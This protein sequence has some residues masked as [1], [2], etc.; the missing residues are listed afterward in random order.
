LRSN[1]FSPTAPHDTG[2]GATVTGTRAGPLEPSSIGARC[3]D[4]VLID[5]LE[6]LV[7]IGLG[8]FA[9]IAVLLVIAFV[10]VKKGDREYEQGE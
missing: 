1:P 3:K 6:D 9:V 5:P 10:K 4:D 7:V 2:T 8:I